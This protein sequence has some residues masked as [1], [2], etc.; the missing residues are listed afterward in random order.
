M[1]QYEYVTIENHRLIG[2]GFEGYRE[3]IDDYAKRGYR[4]AG[5]IPIEIMGILQKFDLVFE[6]E[7]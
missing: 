4:Y 5:L 7:A 2:A 6:R 3:I 1:K